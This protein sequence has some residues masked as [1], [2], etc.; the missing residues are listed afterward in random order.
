MNK[1]WLKYNNVHMHAKQNMQ[2]RQNIAHINAKRQ[3][4]T[5]LREKHVKNGPENTRN[6]ILISLQIA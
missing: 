3:V 5:H 2:K 4:N 1:K 6:R